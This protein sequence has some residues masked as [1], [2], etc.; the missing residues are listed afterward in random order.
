MASPLGLS[1]ATESVAG[2]P[3]CRT[4]RGLREH[5]EVPPCRALRGR[6][7]HCGVQPR[8]LTDCPGVRGTGSNYHPFF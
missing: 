5:C 7:E 2:V 8:R 3:P 6:R 4:L 1:A